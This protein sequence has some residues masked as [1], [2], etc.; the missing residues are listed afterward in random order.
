MILAAGLQSGG[1]TLVSWCFLQRPDCDG[2]LDGDTDLIPLLGEHLTVAENIWFKT[3]IS[4]FTLQELIALL[5]DDGFRVSPMLIVRDVRKT[6]V[7]LAKKHY[8]RNGVT[9]ED[10]PLRLRFRRFLDSWEYARANNIPV[11]KFEQFLKQPEV[12][13]GNICAALDLPWEQA[14]I[15]WPKS[16][17]QIGNVRH[18]NATFRTADKGNLHAAIESAGGDKALGS[19]HE[20]D[21]DWLDEAFGDFNEAMGYPQHLAPSQFLPGRMKPEWAASR[22]RKWRLQQRPLR[23]LLKK[24]GLSS[25][26]PRPE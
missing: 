11:L 10:P 4:S 13:L 25:Y 8:G 20:Q 15:D 12:S 16:A 5:E 23:Y 7:S 26:S 6:W 1:S 3:T 18:G 9:A 2:V 22:R 24:L 21:L 14:M 17:G 19:I